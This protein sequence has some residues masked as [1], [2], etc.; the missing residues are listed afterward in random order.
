MAAES[1]AAS[2]AASPLARLAPAHR[3]ALLNAAPNFRDVGGRETARGQMRV[4]V[5]YRTDQLV[6][7]PAAAQ[8]ALTHLDV[9]VIFDLRTEIERTPAPDDVPGSIAVHVADVLADRPEGGAAQV[10]ALGSALAGG[11]SSAMATINAAIGGGQA[12]DFMVETYR[13]FIRLPSANQAYSAFLQGVAYGSSAVAFHCTAGKDRTGWAAA[14]TQM[15]AGVD[16]EGIRSDY[17]AS[18]ELTHAVFTPMLEAFG[19]AGGDAEALATVMTVHIDYLEA[20]VSLMLSTYGD[21][22]TYLHRGL[23][24]DDDDLSALHQRL[25]G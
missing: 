16:E 10:A 3:D 12:S 21:L 23:G 19:A 11:D 17:L 7:M 20:A 13:D 14:I 15:F 1:A 2:P 9:T 4:G 8:V 22:E 5:L 6:R 25:V 18:N 24:L